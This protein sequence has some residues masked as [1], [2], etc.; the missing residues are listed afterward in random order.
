[1]PRR[2]RDWE[3]GIVPTAAELEEQRQRDEDS[4]ERVLPVLEEVFAGYE[5]QHNPD[6][7]RRHSDERGG[8]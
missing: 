4:R 6:E 7:L 5:T 2:L 8:R 1:V 3:V